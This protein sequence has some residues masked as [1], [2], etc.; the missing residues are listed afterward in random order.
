M[1]ALGHLKDRECAALEI[2]SFEGR[3]AVWFLE[4]ILTHPR[5]I[6]FCI[7][8]FAGSP[9][10]SDPESDDQVKVKDLD[11]IE[12]RFDANIG[13]WEHRVWKLKGESREQLRSC[14]LTLAS[15]DFVYLDGSHHQKDVMRDA[16]MAWDLL[17]PGGVLIFDDYGFQFR[18]I[19]PGI[20]IDMFMIL[21]KDE[22]ELLHQGWQVIVRKK[23]KEKA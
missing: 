18:G 20:A 10:H 1:K 14:N 19:K 15:L 9:E 7:D 12:D 22:A 21:F 11:S 17:R 3:S 13:P 8:T 16:C 5:S 4:N 2:G 23:D 6:L